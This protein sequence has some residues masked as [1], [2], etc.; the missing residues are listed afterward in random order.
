MLLYSTQQNPKPLSNVIFYLCSLEYLQLKT[1]NK[2]LANLLIGQCIQK[3]IIEQSSLYGTVIEG[4]PKTHT[5]T[6]L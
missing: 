1:G 5:F 3:A 6:N 2:E 4:E